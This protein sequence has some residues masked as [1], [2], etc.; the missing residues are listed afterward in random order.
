VLVQQQNIEVI[1]ALEKQLSQV[2]KD[3]AKINAESLLNKKLTNLANLY[4]QDL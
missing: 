4:K 1:Q 3:K 2:D